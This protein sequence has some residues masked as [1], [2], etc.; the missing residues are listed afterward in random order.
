MLPSEKE[1]SGDLCSC[2]IMI[3]DVVYELPAPFSEFEAHGW[4]IQEIDGVA[5]TT[6]TLN[7]GRS[8]HTV[9]VSNG[10]GWAWFDFINKD[11][12]VLGYPDC[13]VTGLGVDT[14]TE[15]VARL[16]LPGN[17]TLGCPEEDVLA[18]YGEPTNTSGDDKYKTFSYSLGNFAYVYIDVEVKTG[19]VIYLAL[20]NSTERTRLPEVKSRP[21]DVV[22]SYTAPVA[23]GTSWDS[24]TIRFEGDLYHVPVPVCVLIDNGWVCISDENRMLQ[25]YSREY[26]FEIRKGNQILSAAISNT[27]DSQQPAKYCLVTALEY[28]RNTS[29]FPFEL[30]VG[31][32]EDSS[33][34]DFISVYGEPDSYNE[35]STFIY[36]TWQNDDYMNDYFECLTVA[37][38]NETSAVYLMKLEN[39][40]K[41]YGIE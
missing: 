21:P 1:L 28:C 20:N 10:S 3:N 9:R 23:L 41:L 39:S 24:F 8:G 36:Y 37:F 22:K 26:S 31:I 6:Q 11:E 30:P 7:P 34:E 16:V 19:K 32:T 4:A 40:H 2:S 17:I 13:M 18:R 29:R 15:D 35:D 12:L 38:D 27:T 33:L 25:A 14:L 5:Y